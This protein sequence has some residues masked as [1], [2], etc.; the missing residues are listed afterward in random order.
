M[1]FSLFPLTLIDEIGVQ[2]SQQ[3]S[4]PQK[5]KKSENPCAPSKEILECARVLNIDMTDYL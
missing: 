3:L 2:Q 4:T 5:E 1:I